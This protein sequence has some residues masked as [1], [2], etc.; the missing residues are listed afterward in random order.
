M[1]FD[2]LLFVSFNNIDMLLFSVTILLIAFTSIVN[3]LS[4]EYIEN[5]KICTTWIPTTGASINVNSSVCLSSLTYQM[6]ASNNQYI[7]RFCCTYR[8][9]GPGPVPKGCGRQAV[10]P[11]RTRIVGGREAAAHS[12]PWLVSLQF[13]ESH[14]CGGTLIVNIKIFFN[15]F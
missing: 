5:G 3:G 12:W 11:I 15:I 2:I 13:D 1:F 14:F 4:L 7:I 6:K 8:T 10:S 9:T